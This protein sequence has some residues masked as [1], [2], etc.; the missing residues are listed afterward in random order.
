MSA[1]YIAHRVGRTSLLARLLKAPSLSTH[2]HQQQILWPCHCWGHWVQ[3]R[4]HGNRVLH[5]ATG[6]R[7]PL[8]VVYRRNLMIY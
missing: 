8:Q 1:M 7:S 4:H 6:R 5:D 3:C 2:Y